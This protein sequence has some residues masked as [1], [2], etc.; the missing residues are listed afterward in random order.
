MILRCAERC[1]EQN[2]AVS[3]GELGLLFGF[4]RNA[5]IKCTGPCEVFSISRAGYVF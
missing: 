2:D 3:L 1:T 5:T 4:K